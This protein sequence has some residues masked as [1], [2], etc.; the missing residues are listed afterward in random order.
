[1]VIARV[2]KNQDRKEVLKSGRIRNVA[3]F[4]VGV[5]PTPLCWENLKKEIIRNVRHTISNPVSMKSLINESTKDTGSGKDLFFPSVGLNFSDIKHRVM[6][7]IG[8]AYEKAIR[9]YFS[10]F[11][12]DISGDL[13]TFIT[14]KCGK[15]K[16]SCQIDFAMLVNNVLVIREIKMNFNIDT[17][18]TEITANRMDEI[19]THARDF[20]NT[21]NLNDCG[22]NV[23][24]TSLLYPF[25]YQIVG[26]KGDLKKKATKGFFTGYKEFFSLVGINDIDENSWNQLKVELGEEVRASFEKCKEKPNSPDIFV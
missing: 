4:K 25:G 11:Y 21:K 26:L 2:K 9:K 14:K 16:R 7:R 23:G 10:K 19:E 6:I 5:S 13:T 24:F 1:M 8:I 22:L 18:K 17:G 15:D 3:G 12:E 20:L